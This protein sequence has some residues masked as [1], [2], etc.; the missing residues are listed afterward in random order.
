MLNATN[1]AAGNAVLGGSF[2]GEALPAVHPSEDLVGPSR[3]GFS[4]QKAP[5]LG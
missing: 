1:A 4:F 3:G 2:W 5:P